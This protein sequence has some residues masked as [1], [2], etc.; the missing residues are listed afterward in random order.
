MF[1][2][3]SIAKTSDKEKLIGS[4]YGIEVDGK[5]NWNF[6]NDFAR[7]LAIFDVDS[8]SSSHA[9]NRKNHFLP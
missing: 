3:T 7:N 6:G 5:G 9:D 4:I 1:G 8:N 2:A